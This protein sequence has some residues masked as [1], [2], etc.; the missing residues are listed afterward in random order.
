M[1]LSKEIT[2]A[3]FNRYPVRDV[4]QVVHLNNGNAHTFLT[5]DSAYA[6]ME[7]IHRAL[8]FNGGLEVVEVN[9]LDQ[10]VDRLVTDAGSIYELI[11]VK[12]EY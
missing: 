6:K 8:S 7:K 11:T 9:D 10:R 3:K 2:A 12:I 4:Y 5:K 1:D